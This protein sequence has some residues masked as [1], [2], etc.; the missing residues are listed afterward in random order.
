MPSGMIRVIPVLDLMSGQVVRGIGGRR[1]EY[2]PVVSKLTASTDPI[3]VAA[4]FRD[5]F[6]LT[7]LYLADLDAIAGQAPA[8]ATYRGIRDLGCRLWV[9][10]GVRELTDWSRRLAAEGVA[11]IV[12][13]LE[14]LA[15]PECAQVLCDEFGE[16]RCLFPRPERG[17]TAGQR[18]RLEFIQLLVHRGTRPSR[19]GLDD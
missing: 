7:D 16:P 19:R 18:F 13:G 17:P 12:A 14:T 11:G 3:A 4:A 10:A 1:S 8:L 6:G 15:G 9:D 5:Q 2:R